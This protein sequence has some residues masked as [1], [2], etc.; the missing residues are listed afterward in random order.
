[1]Y[2][3]NMD[4]IFSNNCLFLVE[5]YLTNKLRMLTTPCF[6]CS[7]VNTAPKV[8]TPSPKSE[9]AFYFFIWL[10]FYVG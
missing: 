8:A 4:F 2:F 9:V 6:T 7:V 5:T 10:S 3:D 1:M